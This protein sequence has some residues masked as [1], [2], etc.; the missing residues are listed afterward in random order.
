MLSPKP[1]IE[2]VKQLAAGWESAYAIFGN[3]GSRFIG[4]TFAKSIK[5]ELIAIVSIANNE[6]ENLLPKIKKS[7]DCAGLQIEASVDLDEAPPFSLTTRIVSPKAFSAFSTRLSQEE[8]ALLTPLY[9]NVYYSLESD[10]LALSQKGSFNDSLIDVL[11]EF[12]GVYES[13]TNVLGSQITAKMSDFAETVKSG[14]FIDYIMLA[15]MEILSDKSSFGPALW[16]TDL[17]LKTYRQKWEKTLLIVEK[18]SSNIN[19]RDAVQ[20]ICEK[21]ISDI[22]FASADLCVNSRP[23]NVGMLA[24]LDEMRDKLVS[25]AKD[26]K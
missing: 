2:N 17:P 12:K 10:L 14:Y 23:H 15:E 9:K 7:F 5:D 4:A 26:T 13:L 24:V 11:R 21:L 22:A 19:A 8:K 20:S 18:M 16:H 25:I 6:F 3:A 1:K